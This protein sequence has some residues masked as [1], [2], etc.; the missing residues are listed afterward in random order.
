MEITDWHAGLVSGMPHALLA[1]VVNSSCVYRPT[2]SSIEQFV[3]FHCATSKFHSPGFAEEAACC[4]FPACALN[5]F[6]GQEPARGC[7]HLVNSS[8]GAALCRIL[9][10]Q[11]SARRLLAVLS[12][13]SEG[14]CA[15]RRKLSS[16]RQQWD[17]LSKH[18]S[19]EG[20]GLGCRVVNLSEIRNFESINRR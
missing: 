10:P 16:P 20:H 3:S 4:F 2:S 7:I 8:H 14:V 6:M 12:A 17:W 1:H 18:A 5:K 15:D 9:E 13:I 11:G 19:A